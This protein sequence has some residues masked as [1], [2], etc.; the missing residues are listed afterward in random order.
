MMLALIFVNLAGGDCLA[1][2]ERLERD[3]GLTAALATVES[4][5]L[6]RAERRAL[7]QRWRRERMRTLASPNT[8]AA[9]LERFHDP[10]P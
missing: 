2:L 10:P 5:L 1:D 9:W 6:T 7:R 3:S 8:T 4:E